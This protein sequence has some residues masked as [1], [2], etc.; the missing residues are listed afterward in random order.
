MF[1]I[2]V[3]L[4]VSVVVAGH[5]RV[6][7]TPQ[8]FVVHYVTGL[9]A[10]ER[11]EG[12]PCTVFEWRGGQCIGKVR[13]RQVTKTTYVLVADAKCAAAPVALPTGRPLASS[14]PPPVIP[15]PTVAPPPVAASTPI[16]PPAPPTALPSVM[17]REACIARGCKIGQLDLRNQ[18]EYNRFR[19]ALPDLQ[20]RGC[21]SVIETKGF[22]LSFCQCP[23]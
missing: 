23:C 5:V 6:R 2:V 15:P 8:G 12:Q 18:G 4:L 9:Q 21:T 11:Q 17:T 22:I 14:P 1:A 3:I 10:A 7:W 13:C 19:L 20:K 16:A